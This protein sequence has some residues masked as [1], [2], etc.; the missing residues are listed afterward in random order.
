MEGSVTGNPTEKAL[1]ELSRDYS[2]I[3]DR[4]RFERLSE[5]PFSSER[6]FMAVQCRDLVIFTWTFANSYF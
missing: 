5:I 4:G 1:L 6:K 3:G 2:L